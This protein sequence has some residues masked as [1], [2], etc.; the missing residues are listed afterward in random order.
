MSNNNSGE[1]MPIL[2]AVIHSM[3]GKGH[4]VLPLSVPMEWLNDETAKSIHSQSL[5]MLKSRGGMSYSEIVCNMHKGNW[6][7]LE[8]LDEYKC[9]IYLRNKIENNEQP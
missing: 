7:Q 4:G 9:M 5:Q 3:N 8:K 6:N 1:R 2:G